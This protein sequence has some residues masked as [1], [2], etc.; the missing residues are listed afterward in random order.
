MFGFSYGLGGNFAC[1]KN[2]WSGVTPLAHGF[3]D[4]IPCRGGRHVW[5]RIS[6]QF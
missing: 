6:R 1:S 3:G 2:R 5:R 4:T